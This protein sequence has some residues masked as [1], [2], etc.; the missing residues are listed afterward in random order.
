[1][2]LGLFTYRISLAQGYLH[3]VYNGSLYYHQQ[4]EARV[5]RYELAS[6]RNTM[7]NLPN[8]TVTGNIYLYGHVSSFHSLSKRKKNSVN[9][10]YAHGAY[11]RVPYLR[12]AVFITFRCLIKR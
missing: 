10:V 9:R 2:C 8:A 12:S 7:V 6:E 4:E 11:S 1:M 5:I 3:V